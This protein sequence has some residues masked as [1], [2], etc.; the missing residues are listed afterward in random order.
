MFFFFDFI[1][2]S[3]M[4]MKRGEGLNC[5]TWLYEFPESTVYF[6]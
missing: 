2:P 3:E 6:Q 4:I 5:S 1:F